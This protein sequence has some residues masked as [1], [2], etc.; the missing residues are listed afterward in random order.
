MRTIVTNP[1]LPTA[2][3]WEA[4][5]YW[6]LRRWGCHEVADQARANANF[7]GQKLMDVAGVYVERIQ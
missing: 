4:T 7:Y 2:H 1:E 6:I 3:Q 5:R